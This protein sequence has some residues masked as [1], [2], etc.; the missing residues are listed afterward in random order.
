MP[1]TILP[2]LTTAEIEMSLAM[3]LR[4]WTFA[5][6]HLTRV[7]KTFGWKGTLMVVNTIG[8]LAEA[9]WHHPDLAVSYA[10]V[11]VRLQSHD[12]GGITRRDI[13]LARMIEQVVCWQPGKSGSSLEGTPQTPDAGYIKYD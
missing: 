2:V 8:H 1:H 12:A 13:D 7:Y 6:N 4:H 5:D 11:E 3:E 9:A 10:K